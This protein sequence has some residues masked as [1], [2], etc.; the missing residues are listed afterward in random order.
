ME[1]VFYYQNILGVV[2]GSLFFPYLQHLFKK[3]RDKKQNLLSNYNYS[4]YTL[5]NYWR[6]SKG[7]NSD[8]LRWENIFEEIESAKEGGDLP[9]LITNCTAS[10]IK[11]NTEDNIL[12]CKYSYVVNKNIEINGHVVSYNLNL[13]QLKNLISFFNEESKN[14][15][16]ITRSRQPIPREQLLDYKQHLSGM[17]SYCKDVIKDR[18]DFV[19]KTIELKS[20][21]ERRLEKKLFKKFNRWLGAWTKKEREEIEVRAVEEESIKFLDKI[22]KDFKESLL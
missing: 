2:L 4:I 21:C 3:R 13:E 15:L 18:E 20:Y 7:L 14:I 5:N 6:Y 17:I 12:N 10:S 22:K 1:Y 16:K 8:I 19:L 11:E 9:A